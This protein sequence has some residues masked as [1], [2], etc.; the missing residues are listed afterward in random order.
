VNQPLNNE[1]SQEEISNQTGSLT[2]SQNQKPE[3]K[4]LQQQQAAQNLG[5]LTRILA[6]IFLTEKELETIQS[7]KN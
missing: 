6:P 4:N 3:N 5:F 7:N 2:Q 1:S